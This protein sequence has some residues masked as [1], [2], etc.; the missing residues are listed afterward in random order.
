M[1]IEFGWAFASQIYP[2][3]GG[4]MS[5][6]LFWMAV[7]IACIGVV[8]LSVG[9]A[10]SK[11]AALSFGLIAVIL[12]MGM[13][14]LLLVAPITSTVTRRVVYA[15]NGEIVVIND[16]SGH[17]ERITLKG[18]AHRDI[19]YEVGDIITVVYNASGNPVYIT[20]DRAIEQKR[21]A[22]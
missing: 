7:A 3:A 17:T 21:T 10:K 16:E 12:A 14:I 13:L 19:S 11:K 20:T 22:P 18:V 15:R 5:S 9:I 6:F 2:N 1:L 4:R 8:L